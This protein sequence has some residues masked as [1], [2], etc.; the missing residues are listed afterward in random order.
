[1]ESRARKTKDR[2]GW[3]WGK[4]ERYK[5]EREGEEETEKQSTYD[6]HTLG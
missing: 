6:R 4:D 3:H 5:R 1:M 2:M